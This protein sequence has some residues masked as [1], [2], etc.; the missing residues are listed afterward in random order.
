[1]ATDNRE[2][3]SSVDLLEHV[4]DGGVHVDSS[5]LGR[6]SARESLL[7]G[8]MTSETGSQSHPLV[9]GRAPEEPKKPRR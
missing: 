9:R 4:T 6:E 3:K 1:M 2:P 8:V 5:L 7:G